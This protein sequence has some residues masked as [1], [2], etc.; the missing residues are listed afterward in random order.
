MSLEF[1]GTVASNLGMLPSDI[2]ILVT[3]LCGVIFMA[4]NLKLALVMYLLVFSTEYILFTFWGLST[5]NIFLII[6]A[7][8]LLLALSLYTSKSEQI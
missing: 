3:V 7:T 5:D 6:L 1:L 4:I 8:I 2:I